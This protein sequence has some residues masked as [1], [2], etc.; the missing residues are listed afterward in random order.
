MPLNGLTETRLNTGDYYEYRITTI[1][2]L[3]R[4]SQLHGTH[5]LVR[6]L[7]DGWRLDI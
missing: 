4:I 5:A 2:G 1:P 3:E 7:R 6:G